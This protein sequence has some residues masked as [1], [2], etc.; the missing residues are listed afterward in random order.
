MVM[1]K[2]FGLLVGLLGCASALPVAA[3]SGAP[4]VARNDNVAVTSNYWTAE[5]MRSAKAYDMPRA[6]AGA[7]TLAVRAA[8]G[9]SESS[10]AHRPSVTGA[11]KDVRLHAPLRLSSA[12]STD[13][14]APTAAGTSGL[15]FTNERVVPMN[16][17]RNIF[18][19]V[20]TGKLFFTGAGG[21]NFV[22]SAS[23][24]RHR[25]VATAGHCVYDS[26]L[27]RF[28]GNFL[29]VPGYDNG[30]SPFGGFTWS[31]ATTT[32]SWASGDGSV[33]N[34]ADFG[35][36]VVNDKVVGGSPRRIGELT[37]WLGWKTNALLANNISAMGY[38]CNLDSCQILQRTSAHVLRA[39]APNS[40]EIGSD[41][42]GGASGGPWVQDWGVAATGQPARELNGNVVVGITSYG[43]TA[44]QPRYLGSSILNNE[45]VAIWNVACRQPRACA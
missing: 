43:P 23:V 20:A 6:A 15:R 31:L 2:Y 40:A 41:H 22:C 3:Q 17:L 7:T 32:V 30:A 27:N 38:P 19:W 34:A 14:V 44:L 36:I 37:G 11:A 12:A 10:P 26:E 33:P 13:E 1:R 25:V 45:W 21:G 5:R 4:L 16:V 8:A 9:A 24:I 18:P 35:M 29:F 42:R 39:R 28:H